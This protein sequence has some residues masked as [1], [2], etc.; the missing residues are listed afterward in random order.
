MARLHWAGMAWP[1]SMDINQILDDWDTAVSMAAEYR[2]RQWIAR[3]LGDVPMRII[4][5]EGYNFSAAI[6]AASESAVLDAMTYGQGVMKVRADGTVLPVSVE[7]M[8]EPAP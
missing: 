2:D 1:V 5:R 6:Q 4:D 3:N 8:I 7:S